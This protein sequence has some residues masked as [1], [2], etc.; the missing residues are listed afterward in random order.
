[1]GKNRKNS[2]SPLTLK[3]NRDS[4]DIR[5]QM[6][7]LNNGWDDPTE[8]IDACADNK[9]KI[10][11]ITKEYVILEMD[12]GTK[13]KMTSA[14]YDKYRATE[15]KYASLNE[16]FEKLNEIPSLFRHDLNE[17]KFD[18]IPNWR[19]SYWNRGNI[20]IN[21]HFLEN[22]RNDDMF[23][24]G[25]IIHEHAHNLD[26]MKKGITEETPM[27]KV[28]KDGFTNND[29]FKKLI[30]KKDVSEYSQGYGE[31]N[32]PRYATESF[33]D[34]MEIVGKARIYGENRIEASILVKEYNEKTGK[35]DE[36]TVGYIEWAKTH[37]E[38]AEFGNKIWDAETLE[39]VEKA[40][41]DL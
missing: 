26:L 14:F 16:M 2:Y 40:F 1:M 22:P 38:L 18:Y 39:D 24:I 5:M 21:A 28:L 34:L 23:I 6:A 36:K 15:I 17:I 19:K 8:L 33:A 25:T 9:I 7:F 37:K 10:G 41:N 30:S 27:E 12:D 20:F 3:E 4:K 13:L 11:E 35:Y 32:D 31:K 29:K